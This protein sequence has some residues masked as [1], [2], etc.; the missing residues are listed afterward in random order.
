MNL[1]EGHVLHC[2][3]P[4]SFWNLPVPQALQT[5]AEVCSGPAS[6]YRPGE[7]ARHR[8]VSAFA[9]VPLLHAKRQVSFV[10]ETP[11]LQPWGLQDCTAKPC[12]SH[13]ASGTCTVYLM[14]FAG[15]RIFSGWLAIE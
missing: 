5:S 10:D 12:I 13:L 15:V 4:C 11:K 6:E 7:Q 14:L 9:Y 8:A 1:P 2:V 3:D